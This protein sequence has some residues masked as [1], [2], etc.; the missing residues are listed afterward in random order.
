[1]TSSKILFVLYL[2]A[3]LLIL[4]TFSE[5]SVPFEFTDHHI[6][7]EIDPDSGTLTAVD[8]ISVQYHKNVDRLY[9]FLNESFTVERI[10]I[11]HQELSLLPVSNED[12]RQLSK[13]FDKKIHHQGT[14]VVQ[15]KIPRSLYA[16]QFQVW[17]SGRTNLTTEGLYWYPILPGQITRMHLTALMPCRYNLEMGAALI[18]QHRDEDWNLCVWESEQS[19]EYYPL[20]FVDLEL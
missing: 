13:L 7:L 17:Y 4:C 15:V 8:T 2:A 10:N 20:H 6:K 14:Q 9:F 19:F 5:N 1:M 16:E 3:P 12:I 11:G 18:E